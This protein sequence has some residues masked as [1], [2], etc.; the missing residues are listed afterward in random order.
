MPSP[1]NPVTYTVNSSNEILREPT[2]DEY[3]FS[4]WYECS[5]CPSYHCAGDANDKISEVPGDYYKEN[6]K[7]LDLCGEFK[8]KEYPIVYYGCVAGD[9]DNPI[10]LNQYIAPELL[11]YIYTHLGERK[12]IEYEEN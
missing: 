6:P 12:E 2:K 5:K 3:V 8:E 10:E 7:N 11:T 1:V 4:G 9:C